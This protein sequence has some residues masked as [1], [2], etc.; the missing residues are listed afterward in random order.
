MES[1]TRK[2]YGPPGTGKTTALTALAIKAAQAFGPERV[3]ALTFTR[4]AA[5]ELRSRIG[6]ALGLQPPVQPWARKRFFDQRLPWVG[7]IHS[8]ALRLLD[9][10]PVLSTRDLTTFIKSMGGEA[11]LADVEPED[12]EGYQWAEPSRDEVEAALAV[13]AMSKHRMIEL[14]QAYAEAQWGYRGPTVSPERVQFLVRAYEDFKRDQG[15]IDFEDMLTLGA[16]HTLPVDAILADEVQDNSP[17]LWNVLDLWS[18]NLQVALAGDPYQSLYKWSGAEPGLFINHVG[19]LH[20]LGD[21]R[22]LTPGSASRAQQILREAGYED[23]EWLGTW[24]GTGS[25]EVTD[26]SQFW[27][28]RTGRLLNPVRQE[29][30]DEGTPYANIRGGGPLSTVEAQAYRVLANLKAKGWDTVGGVA[31]LAAHNDLVSRK[32]VAALRL[33]AR[34]HEQEPLDRDAAAHYLGRDLDM[35][36][37]GFK[38]GDY[39]ERVLAR[40]GTGAFWAEP[41]I[42]VGTIHSAKGR[43]ADVV[44][45]IESWGTLPY[46]ALSNGGAQS[47]ACVAYVGVTR[48]RYALHLEPASEGMPYPF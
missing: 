3:A 4:T 7:T 30:E 6:A 8:V 47:E 15:K 34:E 39:F 11:H 16:L 26:G 22:R 40:H 19:G 38:K 13:Y 1:L 12:A 32:N 43:E 28:A 24:T 23:Q 48:H 31:Y 44:H 45:L 21:S 37:D 35:L 27:L 46:R 9:R 33:Q 36:Q 41:T 29:L 20:R 2:L 25:G 10:Q 5:D 14:A 42:K 18:E 17:L